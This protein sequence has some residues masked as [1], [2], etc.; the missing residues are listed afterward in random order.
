MIR[1]YK[2]DFRGDCRTERCEQIDAAG[3]LEK[4]HPDRW[5]LI[6]HT[7]NETKG[8]ARH[9][10][11][12]AK[13]G[14]KPGVPDL[15]DANGPINGFFELKRLDPNKSRLSADQRKFLQ[16]AADRGHF[17]AVCYGFEQFKLAYVDFLKRLT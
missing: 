15:I 4:H 10:Q 13:E 7:P 11:M 1:I 14:T 16:A 8:T 12:R 6:W 3:W 5:P 2:G 9:M 17:V